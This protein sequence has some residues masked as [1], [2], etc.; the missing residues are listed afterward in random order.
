MQVKKPVDHEKAKRLLRVPP[1]SLTIRDLVCPVTVDYEKNRRAPVIVT[2]A[3]GT[4]TMKQVYRVSCPVESLKVVTKPFRLTRFR[5]T[6]DRRHRENTGPPLDGYE[7]IAGLIDIAKSL[8]SHTKLTNCSLLITLQ[9]TWEDDVTYDLR[10]NGRLAVDRHEEGVEDA[11][12]TY[13]DEVKSRWAT[14]GQIIVPW[15]RGSGLEH[16]ELVLTQELPPR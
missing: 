7:L 11:L 16:L 15:A 12:R 13:L 1:L 6:L 14:L 2:P 10:A 9:M 8:E 3:S 5:A 4:P